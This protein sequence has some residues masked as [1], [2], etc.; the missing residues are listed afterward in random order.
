MGP[1]DAG[2][3]IMG[4]H[5]VQWKVGSGVRCGVLC[6]HLK[7]LL[8]SKVLVL[9]GFSGGP[10]FG[11]AAHPA[12]RQSGLDQEVLRPWDLQRTVE[13]PLHD[14]QRRTPLHL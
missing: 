3:T 9:C 14:P 8:S 13:E 2:D 10:G 11:P 1:R 5:Q 6:A 7:L 4:Y 12:A